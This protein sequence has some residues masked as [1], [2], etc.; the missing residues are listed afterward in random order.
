MK[1]FVAINQDGFVKSKYR[2][3]N[4]VPMTF[5]SREEFVNRFT[6]SKNPSICGWVVCRYDENKVSNLESFE[7]LTLI[8]IPDVYT[9][10][11]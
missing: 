8:P 5:G 2:G 9:L 10:E 7:V 6:N 3:P 1:T 4:V 11:G